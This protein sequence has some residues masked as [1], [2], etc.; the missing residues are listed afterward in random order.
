MEILGTTVPAV[1]L[2]VQP[3]TGKTQDQSNVFSS[4]NIIKIH[5]QNISRLLMQLLFLNYMDGNYC[6]VD[7]YAHQNM[8]KNNFP[9][10][11]GIKI[12]Y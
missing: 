4:A 6:F 9:L 3:H 5:H 12:F 10:G 8:R 11:L 7:S 1:L 2:E